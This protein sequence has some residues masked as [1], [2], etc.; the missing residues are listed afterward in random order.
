MNK[1]LNKFVK[2][3]VF[4]CIVLVHTNSNYDLDV[5]FRGMTISTEKPTKPVNSRRYHKIIYD[6]GKYY[7][8]FPFWGGRGRK[9]KS[10]H[11]DQNR[12]FNRTS[13]FS[14]FYGLFRDF[15]YLHRL[16][17]VCYF[18]AQNRL[19][20]GYDHMFDHI[21]HEK[22]ICHKAFRHFAILILCKMTAVLCS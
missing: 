2:I 12:R 8:I 9:F 13:E 11:S 17:N 15:W 18:F 20:I 21:C 7:Q 3:I 22:A 14:L 16:E 6:N 4:W 10:C 1:N 5:H 19:K